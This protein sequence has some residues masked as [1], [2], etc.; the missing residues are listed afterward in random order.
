MCAEF[1]YSSA[2]LLKKR[3]RP[4]LVRN[5]AQKSRCGQ[6][7]VLLL[8]KNVAV[9]LAALVHE[10]LVVVDKHDLQVYLVVLSL[11]KKTSPSPSLASGTTSSEWS[12]PHD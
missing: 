4:E 6:L 1:Q 3:R 11:R 10:Q 5:M 2:A 7:Y 12:V 8:D 9:V